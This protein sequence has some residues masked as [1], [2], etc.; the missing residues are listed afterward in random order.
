MTAGRKVTKTLEEFAKCADRLVKGV[1]C[2]YQPI[3]EMLEEPEYIKEVPYSTNMQILKFHK[4]Y[5]VITRNGF[6][7]MQLYFMATDGE[8]LH[9]Q[10]YKKDDG[11]EACGHFEVVG[12]D[13]I[14]TIC[15]KF[16]DGENGED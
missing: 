9:D 8:S 2:V 4:A 14:D 6:H 1:H 13:R 11:T 5:R 10:W 16:F 3:E 7:Y 15:A 12:N